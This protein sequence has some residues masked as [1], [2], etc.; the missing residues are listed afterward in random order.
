M[1]FGFVPCPQFDFL[2]VLSSRGNA[3]S[4]MD[5]PGIIAPGKEDFLKQGLVKIF[6]IGKWRFAGNSLELPVKIG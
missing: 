5:L 3:R 2:A 4:N 1:Y 6:T